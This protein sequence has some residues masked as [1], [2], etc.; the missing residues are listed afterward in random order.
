[1]N[2]K[3]IAFLLALVL[4]VT[5]F[6]ACGNSKTPGKKNEDELEKTPDSLNIVTDEDLVKAEDVTAITGATDVNGNVVD[7][8][9][10]TDKNGHKIY[11]TGQKDSAGQLIYTTGKV[12]SKG[13]VLYT[14]NNVD[15]FGNLIYYIICKV[16]IIII[17]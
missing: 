9:G 17:R 1:M 4:I 6:A 10:I 13:N 11:S 12:D 8:V 15:S 14:K 3:I 16:K 5:T 2:K 7:R